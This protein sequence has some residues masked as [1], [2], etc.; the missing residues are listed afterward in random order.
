LATLE[1]AVLDAVRELAAASLQVVVEQTQ[2][3]LR[4]GRRRLDAACPR[5][6]ERAPVQSWRRRTVRTTCG[7]I[8]M[9]RPWYRCAGCHQGFSVTDATLGIGRGQR[10]SP[11]LREQITLVGTL[12][13]FEE[14]ASVLEELTGLVVAAETVRRVT[15]AAG[16]QLA[17][18]DAAATVTVLQGQEPPNRVAPQAGRLVV[19]TDGVMVPYRDGWHEVK[20]GLVGWHRQGRLRA[21]SYTAGRWGAAAFGPYLLMEAARRGALDVVGWTGGV[22]ERGLARLRPVTV[23]GDGARWI[24]ELAAAHFGERQEVVD[25]YHASQHVWELGRALHGAGAA[26]WAEPHLERL[27]QGGAT[28]LLQALAGVR[29]R[30]P[31]AAAVLR[32]E[33]GY[34]RTNCARM[35]YPT[36]RQQDQPLGSGSVESAAKHLVQ[37]RLKRAG[38]RWSEAGAHALLTLRCRRASQGAAAA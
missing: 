6:Q 17:A 21:C 28:A 4:P 37:Q 25:W 18:Q 2:R 29:P 7:T 31:E 5:C 10:L 3:S 35:A 14:A 36:L 26:A 34:F 20:I 24:W 12:T 13:S 8:T 22:R 38:A 23:V 27:W 30:K 19:E 1:T 15:E 33:R 16:T 9:E 32:R 11:A